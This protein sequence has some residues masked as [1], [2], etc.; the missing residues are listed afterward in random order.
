MT[1][2]EKRR[3]SRKSGGHRKHSDGGF[4][5]TSSGGSFLDEND[6]EVSSLT[7]R[8]F[9]SL[10]IGDEAVYNDSDLNGP[11]PS[12][13]RDRQL[14]F[15]QSGQDI[16]IEGR[17]REELKRA[18]HEN[19]NL[20]MQQYGQDWIHGGMYASENH[21]GPQWEVY[22][23]RT[24]GRVSATFQ[25]SYVETSQQGKSLGEEELS[26][27][28]N[29]AS[30]FS[31][32]QCRSRSRVSSLIKA[33]NS[34]GHRDGAG[35]DDKP[36]EWIDETSW[37]KSALMSI[38][39][40]LSEFSTSYQQNF[41]TSHF[42]P[43]SFRDTNY[44]SSEVAAVTHMSHNSA[45][46]YMRSSHTQR[47]MSAQ[48]NSNSNFFIHS[49]F[50][51]FKV[52]R[53]HNRFPFRQGEVSGFMHRSEFPKWYETPMYKE[54]S[55]ENQPQSHYRSIRHPRNN[56]APVALPT[57]PGS[58]LTSSVLQK[59][60]AVEKRC[61]SEL[62]GHYPHRKRTQSLGNHKLP[63]QR[64]STASPTIEISRR[65][66]DT[67]SSVKALQQKIKMMTGQNITT[68]EIANQQG[69]SF[70]D[71][72]LIHSGNSA[73][74]VEPN[75]VHTNTSTTPF[76][77]SQL[78]TPVVYTHQEADTSAFQQYDVSPQPVEHPPVRAE[79]RGATPDIRMASYKSRAT[80]LLFNLK[81]NRKRVKSTYSPTKFKGLDTMEKNNKPFWQEPRETVVDIPNFPDPDIQFME[82][83]TSSRTN[84]AV[85]PYHSPGL[86]LTNQS[87]Q[88][89]RANTGQYPENVSSDYQTAQMQ[90]QMVPHPGFSGFI[91][92]NYTS[93]QLVNGQNPHEY[94]ASFTPYKQGMIEN[95]GTLGGFK[96]PCMT[97][98]SA[99]LNADNNQSREYLISK[100]NTEQAFNETVGRVFTKVDKYEQ[101]KHNKHDYNNMSSQNNWRQTNSVDTE[102]LSLKEAISPSRQETAALKDRSRQ[103]G[104]PSRNKQPEK[105]ECRET[106]GFGI[107]PQEKAELFVLKQ[108]E[109]KKN[110][111]LTQSYDRYTD[112]EYRNQLYSTTDK[113]ITTEKIG[114]IKQNKPVLREREKESLQQTKVEPHFEKDQKN[115]SSNP[116]SAP[117]PTM[118]KQMTARQN[119]EAR[120]EE[121]IAE[122]IKAQHAQA[123]LAKA[124]QRAQVEQPKA[125]SAGLIL[126]E[127][128]GTEEV[129][130]E[131]SKSEPT[132]LVSV[133]QAKEEV[134]IAERMKRKQMEQS[135]ENQPQQAREEEIMAEQTRAQKLTDEPTNITEKENKKQMGEEQDKQVKAEQAET[136]KLN[137]EHIKTE[138]AKN[139]QAGPARIKQVKTEQLS[140][141]QVKRE[142]VEAEQ[143]KA[144]KGIAEQATAA[145]KKAEETEQTE[146][147]QTKTKYM[148]TK[149]VMREVKTDTKKGEDVLQ[150]KGEEVGRVNAD[151]PTA[152][153]CATTD[154]K[155]EERRVLQ[156][157]LERTKVERTK[158]EL[159]KSEN[160]LERSAKLTAKL[161]AT[162]QVRSEPDKVEQ[163]K[164]ELAKAK[165]ELAKIKEKM[166][167]EQKEKD[168]NKPNIKESDTSNS[169]TPLR[170]NMDK[171][172]DSKK[173]DQAVHMQTD[174]G[175]DD[176]DR[177][178][179][180]YGL[181][182]AMP[183][184]RSK[185]STT[186]S[187]ASETKVETGNN[188]KANDGHS[189]TST[190]MTPNKENKE[191]VSSFKNSEV[192]ESKHAYDQSSKGFKLSSANSFPKNVGANEDN[193]AD[194]L[195]ESYA[196]KVETCNSVKDT[197]SQQRD[198]DLAKLCPSERKS[199][200]TGRA[201][202]LGKDL[203][204]NPLKGLSHKER[205]QTKQE[206]LTSKIKAHA[207]KEISAIKEKGFALREGFIG[208]GPTKRLAGSQSAN[209]WQKPP[210]QEVSKKHEST[211][212][213]NISAKHSMEPSGVQTE[214]AT[215]VSPPSTV[216]IPVKSAAT[217]TQLA[218]HLEKSRGANQTATDI[219]N[220]AEGRP[221]MEL[222]MKSPV[223]N[224]EQIPMTNKGKVENSGKLQEEPQ[225]NQALDSD[226]NKRMDDP[227]QA[228]WDIATSSRPFT[229]EKVV[230]EEAT[231]E[232]SAT[233]NVVIGQIETPIADDNLQIMGIMVSVRERETSVNIQENNKTE[234]EM[235]ATEKECSK[236]ELLEWHPI[237]GSDE[238]TPS[239]EKENSTVNAKPPRETQPGQVAEK[240]VP[241][242]VTI[243]AEDKALAETKA[244]YNKDTMTEQTK[245]KTNKTAKGKL[246]KSMGLKKT[247]GEKNQQQM[248]IMHSNETLIA[249]VVNNGINNSNEAETVKQN[250]SVK[251][252]ITTVV[253]YSKSSNRDNLGA[254]QPEER[255]HDS[256]L[257][258]TFNN[259]TLSSNSAEK[260]DTNIQDDDVHIDSIAIKV[261]RAVSEKDDLSM[262]GKHPITTSPSNVQLLHEHKQAASL[263]CE[264]KANTL[265]SEHCSKDL[266]FASNEQKTKDSA[267]DKLAVQYVLSS[268]KK[269]SD[270]LKNSSKQISTNTTKSEA[271]NQKPESNVQP[272]EG[273]YFQVQAVTE[274]S[275]ETD[276]ST[277]TAG[278]TSK[279]MELLGLLPEKTAMNNEMCEEGKSDVFVFSVG[280]GDG[281]EDESNSVSIQDER[282]ESKKL[283]TE[284]TLTSKNSELSLKKWSNN[285][286]KE[287]GQAKHIKKHY[288]D[289][290]S[291]DKQ[292]SHSINSHSAMTNAVAQ[293]SEG[294]PKPKE[295]V[296]SIPEISAIA[297]YAR[298]KVIVSED[299]E[300]NT[301]QE[302]PPNKKE[303]F[304]PLIQTR[305][306]RRPVFTAD[307][308]DLSVKDKK[309]PNKTEI[310]MSTKVSKEPKA[311]VFPIMEKE[312][313]RT[314]MF[315]LGDKD[316]QERTLLNT[317]SGGRLDNAAKYT[318]HKETDKSPTPQTQQ[319]AGAGTQ[320]LDQS[321][322][323]QNNH[324]LQATTS[325]NVTDMSKG[326]TYLE[327]N[328]PP[329]ST[330]DQ[331][332][333]RKE[334]TTLPSNDE[335]TGMQQDK[336]TGAKTEYGR[337]YQLNKERLTTQH[338]EINKMQ[339]YTRKQLEKD[340]SSGSEKEKRE[341]H[342]RRKHIIQ[343]SRASLVE[344][345]KGATQREEERR[346]KECEATAIMIKERRENQKQTEKRA[347]EERKA[348]LKEEARA[349][350]KFEEL[351]AKQWEEEIRVTE[352]E[353]GRMIQEDKVTKLSEEEEQKTRNEERMWMKSQD[354]GRVA[355]ME[356]QISA[357]HEEEKQRRA[358]E[359]QQRRAKQEEQQRRAAEEQQRRAKQEEQ[360]RRA[361]EEQQRRAAEEQQR[362]AKEEEQQRRAAE[363][364]QRRAAEEQ[365]RR[366]KEE[367]QQRR[368]AEEQQRRAKEE[369]QQKR[370]AEEQQKKAEQEKQQRRAEQEEKQRRAAEEQQRRAAEEQQRRAEQEEKQRRAADEQ[371]RRAAEEQQRRAE[372]EKQQRRAAEEQQRRAEQEKQERR[373]A[374]EQQRRAEQE[375]QERRA[376]E[377]QQRRDEQEKQQKRAAEE[378]QRRAEQEKQQRRAAE[379]QQR[380]AE[381]E[382]QERRAAEEQQRRDEQE[383]QQRRA[384]EEQQRRDEQEKQ[385]RRAAEEQQRRDEQEK[386][387]RRAA[388]EQQRRAEQEK[389]ERRAAEEQQRRAEQEKQQRRAAEEQQRRD[390]QEKQQRRAAEEQQRRDE[391]EKQ[392]R[393]A[394]EEQQR[395]AE[396]EKQ[397]RRLAEEQQ[398]RAEQEKQQRR[399]AEE[400][401]R[402]AEQEQQRRAEQEKQQR[403]AAEE[404]QRR[405]E[406][407][408]QM[409]AAEEQQRRDEQEQQ[410]RAAEEQQRRD[411]QEQQRRAAEEQQMKAE[412]EK[413]Q[414]RAA[415]EQQRRAEQ[416]K[417]QRRAAEEQQ[418]KAEQ[419]KQQ[420]RL[421]EEQQRR[422][423]QEKQQRRAAEEQQR[424]AEQEQQRRAEQEKQQRRAA[425]EQQRRAEQEQQRRAE[426]E[427]QQRRA[428]EEQQRRAEQE[429]QMRAAEEQQRRDEQEQQMRAAEE[430]QRRDE[431]EQQRRAAE[432]QQM[433]AEQEKQQRRAAEEQQRRAEQEKQQR[434]A[435]EEQQRRA[436]QE[437]KQRR[438][439][440]EKQQRRAAEEQQ[441]R[442]EQEEKQ[443]RAEQEKQQRR[444]AEEQQ[445]RAEQE[446]QM[447]AEQEKQ[448][449]RAAE[450]QQRRAA[451]EDQQNRV[452]QE[453]Q[454]MSVVKTEEQRQA[455]QIK[456]KILANIVEEKKRTQRDEENFA[457]ISEEE[458]ITHIQEQLKAQQQSKE[459]RKT[460]SQYIKEEWMRAHRDEKEDE[461]RAAEKEKIV[462]EIEEKQARHEST[463]LT[464]DKRV[465]QE[466]MLTNRENEIQS[467]TKEDEKNKSAQREKTRANQMEMQKRAA[468]KMD[469]LQ[470]YAITST[471]TERKPK[472]R[473]Q[474][475]PLPSPQRNIP[476]GLEST[477]DSSYQIRPYRP[478]APA[479][480]APS[481]PRSNTSSPALGAKPLMFRVKDNTLRGSPFTK[482]VK[483]RFHKN[484]GED[485]WMASPSDRLSYRG[486]N[487][488]ETKRRSAG[489]PVYPDVGS[490]RFAAV[491]ESSTSLSTSSLQD[492]STY[493][494]YHRPRSRR[495]IV[496]DEDES[497]SVISNMSED[498]ESFA[499]S[500]ADLAD[501]RSLYDYD[502]PES[503]CSFSSDVSRSMGKPPAVPPKSEKALRRAQRLTSRRIKKELSKAA[504]DSPA[505]AEEEA[506]SVPSSSSTEVCSSNRHAMASPHFSPPVSLARAP[507]LGSSLLSSHTEQQSSHRSF[508]ASP[509]ATGPISLPIAVPHASSTVSLPVVSPHASGLASQPAAPKTVAHVPSSPPLHHA[510]HPTPVTQ[511]HVEST[512]YPQSFPLTQRK[513]LQDLGSGQYFVVDVPVQV[514][515]KT[516]FDP[517]T[518]KYVQLN[519]RESG[520][521]ISR[522]QSQQTCTQPQLQPQ[523]LIKSQIQPSSQASTVGKSFMLYEGHPNYSQSYQPAAI[524]SVHPNRSSV[525][526]TLLQDQQLPRDS[527]SVTNSAIEVTPNSEGNCY[528]PEKTPYLDT[529]NDI[530]K[531]FSPVHSTQESYESFSD[532]D[533]NSQLARSSVRENEPRDIITMSELEDFMELSDW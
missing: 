477:D 387:Q 255:S 122:H 443:R 472:E 87:S 386:Q 498:V 343:E 437:E 400:Q 50:S 103:E 81:D 19:F 346:A 260:K 207:E 403:R 115:L 407:E 176:Y 264:D 528:S 47:S 372:Q 205:A 322:G 360:Q 518:G 166:R 89:T 383:K 104:L 263:C 456:E 363:E 129:K 273:N 210:S 186:E 23:E 312:H 341:E 17:E 217:A 449:R 226:I 160:L 80:S 117:F 431:Q 139:E 283:E 135:R 7:D 524:N 311:L 471:D 54:L 236:S 11:S 475:S 56:L 100:A 156:A 46:S 58:T 329:N 326:L 144:E 95:V 37:D 128:T 491:N 308:Q 51:P 490:N 183:T 484:Y 458:K 398:R 53:D 399:A 13:Q 148:K 317:K 241:L 256:T 59:A 330:L 433:K 266:T 111:H 408:Q 195:K 6:R 179:E 203:H 158:A 523:M 297:D 29:G 4:S 253:N 68:G 390:E 492:H 208:K 394:A 478:R 531:M 25:H 457:Q 77:I 381:Q 192:T 377:E 380:R 187:D 91:P 438:A 49:E 293:K 530:N 291:T 417:Q 173:Q 190:S 133:R 515:T 164:T 97:M 118:T 280:Q 113:P 292:S 107:P 78:L 142:Q 509:H 404:Q 218:D 486:D 159:S 406:Q 230:S 501:V 496:T 402:R 358:A 272:V 301:F 422:A 220:K 178:R 505:R 124:Q 96:Q 184:N 40:E 517:E 374:E 222:G 149:D 430:Q 338:E 469:T 467:K 351:Q 108:L 67:I 448:Q 376:A 466:L 281:K 10:C 502:R 373:A 325:S 120:G 368:A 521:S 123:E 277:R 209:I 389:Q 348:Q 473:Q 268:V 278:V 88:S 24:Q 112:R 315:K 370:A 333:N 423:E 267:E 296:S 254:T 435:A 445:R 247:D 52:W 328:S 182:N 285:G 371:Q 3:S 163:V 306:S 424:R 2:V 262:V 270:S 409:R 336:D 65:V 384:A 79:S 60:S 193:S 375:K 75:V 461:K 198:S 331:I 42:P 434:R 464:E 143:I 249:K 361:A 354:E 39:R 69:V 436:E 382:K 378:Q 440:Q 150:C 289:D 349:A 415:E 304:F 101:L 500:A 514:K 365:Q 196:E 21:R 206:I 494:S 234:K 485:L 429:Q 276:N 506:S 480:P 392:E 342:I 252:D 223:Q 70:R 214:A 257:P 137:D 35:M 62:V 134:N 30:K 238:N 83:D 451:K 419:E 397:Q 171:N 157:K 533:A 468:Q 302:F 202:G 462:R 279:E 174:R 265:N 488:Q 71:D 391:Q 337:T 181:P 425:E 513:V 320:T 482:S 31:S 416:E 250:L 251:E 64:P 33:F 61:E 350:Q 298:L 487:E 364:Q 27:L 362:R 481:L 287:E 151:K 66:K 245:E 165:A 269:L 516:F 421:A 121:V 131:V 412:Q 476:V 355:V 227:T 327:K 305:H 215:I 442:A 393:R 479:S 318:N 211:V 229:T 161:A 168:R 366:A 388:E 99:R 497:R 367:E 420:R 98:D 8:A 290:L 130:T 353:E 141:E 359:E 235:N 352:I 20:R 483:P 357:P 507:T 314:G 321:S 132:K 444:A 175:A 261:V 307:P 153:I 55:L 231:P 189:P 74:A 38:Q 405:A 356:Q 140:T 452:S 470:Y 48:V 453:E 239:N 303:G 510:K 180:K 185:V 504:A 9:R 300:V 411:E 167:G 459:P 520:Q 225:D 114:Q 410:M 221:Q 441:R 116:E 191:E 332:Q 85:N 243:P 63:S 84:A 72:N 395:K 105:V 237:S 155:L 194:K 271:E 18:A 526:A 274:I 248:Q 213:N 401:Q 44:C 45:S 197:V 152:Q 94:L 258:K 413:Q 224:K 511:Y 463:R 385:Q 455:N 86:S 22:G 242:T 319:M 454:Q 145:S 447:K 170:I 240:D 418:R 233:L 493:F 313:Q 92:E 489:T 136:E 177:L 12:A 428:A 246:A 288:T 138:L 446:Q 216:T 228:T 275:R 335:R 200:S 465:T 212:S 519:V 432:E 295:R 396:Q 532:C 369:E 26:F 204:V 426:Q 259:A 339:H 43:F 110:D 93:N 172:K 57:P 309:L 495:S 14:A 474:S 82:Q 340:Q 76:K 310:E 162:Q 439:E 36:R 508:H 1:S 119:I 28:S 169:I 286:T 284:N 154:T 316:K 5:D 527:H 146:K 125:E 32:Q 106:F 414:R 503:A 244:V 15:S 201:V 529:V 334:N 109:Q 90:G 102:K 345:E 34:D 126:A 499:T 199:K 347:E 525:T 522:P 512:H 219:M 299:K 344:E 73:V 323:Q 232:D 379:E 294:K 282:I 427:K 16:D 450:E 324:P 460:Y 188:K 41:D 147:P 127:L